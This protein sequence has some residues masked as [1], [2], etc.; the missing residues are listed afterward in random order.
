M[1]PPVASSRARPAAAAASGTPSRDP[2]SAMTTSTGRDV[3]RSSESRKSASTSPGEYVTT[4][5]RSAASD[6]VTGHLFQQPQM[7]LRAALPGELSSALCSRH[8]QLGA[9]PR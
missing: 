6:G 1:L 9:T 2:L 5:T 3:A 8:G 4:T 7:R